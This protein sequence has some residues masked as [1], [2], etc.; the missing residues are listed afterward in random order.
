MGMLNQ[1]ND[2]CEKLL[3]EVHEA[4]HE[5]VEIKQVT[6]DIQQKMQLG[7]LELRQFIQDFV[8]KLI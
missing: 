2:E 8:P 1:T 5:N 4:H 3:A 7:I 6:Q